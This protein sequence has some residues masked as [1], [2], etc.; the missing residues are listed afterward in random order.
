VSKE[1]GLRGSGRWG[2]LVK[3]K[4]GNRKRKKKTRVEASE[5]APG[6]LYPE[7]RSRKRNLDMSFVGGGLKRAMW[8][9]KGCWG[10]APA[11][12]STTLE[13]GKKKLQPARFT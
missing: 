7:D 2:T 4:K 8:K 3:Q 5:N 13:H 9:N 6:E 1:T 10:G 12:G 11:W